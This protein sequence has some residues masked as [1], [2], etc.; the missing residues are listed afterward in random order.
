MDKKDR[1]QEAH[2]LVDYLHAERDLSP[3]ESVFVMLLA[4][5]ALSHA[6][7]KVGRSRD[8]AEE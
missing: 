6:L 8:G 2:R 5:E 1:V 4:I 3:I 7:D